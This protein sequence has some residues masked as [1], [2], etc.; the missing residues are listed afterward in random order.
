MKGPESRQAACQKVMRGAG[1]L[2]K[3]KTLGHWKNQ[4]P[5]NQIKLVETIA[6]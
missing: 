1:R 2:K 5:T 4:K 3:I 6:K